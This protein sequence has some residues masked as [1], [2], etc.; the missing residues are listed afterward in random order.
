MGI[1][2][3]DISVQV[4]KVVLAQWAKKKTDCAENFRLKFMM[5]HLAI[6]STIA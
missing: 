3:P 6:W 4:E 5:A 2:C 1:V